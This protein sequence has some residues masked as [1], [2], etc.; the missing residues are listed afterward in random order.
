MPMKWQ[1]W[2]W[3]SSLSV[4]K[5][6]ELLTALLEYLNIPYKMKIWHRIYFGGGSA[7]YENPPN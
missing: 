3:E 2:S 7:N 5:S 1:K 6:I 4:Y